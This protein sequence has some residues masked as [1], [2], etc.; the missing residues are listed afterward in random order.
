MPT[1]L[2]SS[3]RMFSSLD[4]PSNFWPQS[5]QM[6]AHAASTAQSQHPLHLLV[7]V[8]HF[9]SVLHKLSEDVLHLL[10]N[11]GEALGVGRLCLVLVFVHELGDFWLFWHTS[12][13][14]LS[15]T[16]TLPRSVLGHCL[17]VL[18]DHDRNLGLEKLLPLAQTFSLAHLHPPP[19]LGV[20][21]FENEFLGA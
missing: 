6:S 21:E 3:L 15:S 19:V 18:L 5:L 7:D 13:K 16:L 4:W 17:L 20:A 12:A 2:Y 14:Q 11:G 9:L 8:D 1:L 10:S